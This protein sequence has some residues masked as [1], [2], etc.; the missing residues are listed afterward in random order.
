MM[1][2]PSVTKDK[3]LRRG[4]VQKTPELTVFADLKFQQLLCSSQR[5]AL[6]YLRGQ[7]LTQSLPEGHASFRVGFGAASVGV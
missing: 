2:K 3:P 5:E 4:Q 6:P 7:S 1:G